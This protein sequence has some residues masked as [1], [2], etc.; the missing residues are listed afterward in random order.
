MAMGYPIRLRV[1]IAGDDESCNFA[2]GSSIN[3]PMLIGFLNRGWGSRLWSAVGVLAVVLSS[4]IR[5][6]AVKVD[7]YVGGSDGYASFRIPALGVAPDGSVLAFCEGRRQSANDHGAI[8]VLVR[9]S[10]DH[11]L[12]WGPIQI[13]WSD[14]ANTCGNPTVVTDRETGVIWLFMTWNRGTETESQILSGTAQ[15][16]RRVWVT[17]SEDQGRHWASPEDI[18]AQVKSP[19]WRWYATGPGNGIQLVRGS[20]AGRLVIPANHS[21]W[22]E[23]KSVYRAHVFYSDDHGKSWKL[24]GV[25]GDQTNESAV[26]EL[27]DG[28]L[29]QN[30]RSYH[31]KNRRAIA[32]SRDS[33]ESWSPVTLDETLIEP[34]CQASLI[35]VASQKPGTGTVLA[36]SNPASLK[37]ERLTVRFSPDGGTTWPGGEVVHAGPAGYSSLGLVSPTSVG[38][39]FENG[40]ESPYE[41]ISLTWVPVGHALNP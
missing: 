18:T 13:V 33:G 4:L 16:S 5:A 34:V 30:M 26:A 39:L 3:V 2:E 9:R 37:R 23:G 22:R 11:G 41:R 35:S 10:S 14:S 28:R 12:T 21:I 31:G 27:D 7:V 15:E 8:E 29:L 19:D 1:A 24:G 32:I 25:E 6:E 36:F 40:L 17:H 38:C 20:H